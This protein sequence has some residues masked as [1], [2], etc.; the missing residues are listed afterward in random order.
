MSRNSES[1]SIIIK[2]DVDPDVELTLG[3]DVDLPKELDDGSESTP[4]MEQVL[5]NMLAPSRVPLS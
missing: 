3:D 1:Q 5:A 2:F 4:E